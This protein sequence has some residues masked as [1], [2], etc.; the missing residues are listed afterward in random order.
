[1]AEI[2]VGQALGMLQDFAP[3]EYFYKEEYDN[4]GLILGDKNAI[5][6][7]ILCCLDVTE[8]V[9]DEA[10]ELGCELIISHHPLI[11]CPIQNITADT[12][13]GRKLLK[14]AQNGIAVYAAHT[15]LDFVRDGIN[16]YV[17]ALLGLRNTECLSPYIDAQN[18][19]GR[20]GDLANKVYCTVLKGEVETALKDS[21]VRIIGE[22][23]A[24]VK[25]VAV[26]NGAGGGDTK[27]IDMAL[28]AEAD[29]L[30]TADV[31]HHVAMYA[32]E[33]GL[34]VIEPQHFT[35]EHCYISRLVQI[36]KIE[37]KARK[38]EI[39]IFQ[40]TAEVNPRF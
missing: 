24:Q 36:L 7:K 30:V 19:F 32:I 1:M 18:G 16:D 29:C 11:F 2:T 35:M 38:A 34:T 26:I 33:S 22:P 12:V 9:I 27:Y 40:S 4:I 5:V 3:E 23:Y 21:Y 31:K 15:N 8:R 37:A 20:V 6:T 17:A 14:A 39:E 13:L 25:R 28:A 10:V